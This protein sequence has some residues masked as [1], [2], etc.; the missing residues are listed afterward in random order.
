M[1]N[2]YENYDL[3]SQRHEKDSRHHHFHYFASVSCKVVLNAVSI[4]LLMVEGRGWGACTM[5][6]LTYWCET[7]IKMF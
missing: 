7:T 6:A 3:L 2:N 5:L 4:L 1:S